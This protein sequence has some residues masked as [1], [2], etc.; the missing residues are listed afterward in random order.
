[1]GL[2]SAQAEQLAQQGAEQAAVSLDA[3]PSHVVALWLRAE[4]ALAR[5]CPEGRITVRGTGTTL[6]MHV[7][8]PVHDV[9]RAAL[10][11]FDMGGAANGLR[12]FLR[13]DSPAR[14]DRPARDAGARQR[15]RERENDR[16]RP[17]KPRDTK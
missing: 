7:Q 10:G 4:A 14:E 3:L 1:V 9:S 15:P 6:T 13:E 17:R 5:A 16:V 12:P 11:F 8:V 2:A